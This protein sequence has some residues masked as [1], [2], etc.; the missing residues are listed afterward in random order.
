[1]GVHEWYSILGKDRME[2]AIYPETK[3]RGMDLDGVDDTKVDIP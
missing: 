3:G 2:R 1:L